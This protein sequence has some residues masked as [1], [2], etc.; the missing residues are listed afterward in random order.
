M[1]ACTAAAPCLTFDKAYHAAAAGATVQVAAGTYGAQTIKVDSTKNTASSD[2]VIQPATGA[3]VAIGTLLVQGAHVEIDDMTTGDVKLDGRSGAHFVTMRRNNIDGTFTST[4]AHDWLLEGGQV[5]SATPVASDPQIQSYG[6]ALN[7][8]GTVDG[9]WFHDFVD[10]GP[11]KLHHIECL[12]VGSGVNLRIT[13]NHFGPNCDTH[14]LF[15]R[16]WGDSVNGGPSPLTNVHVDGN[17]FEKCLPGCY[18]FYPLDDLYTLSPTSLVVSGNTFQPGAG[19]A[20]NW[21]HGSDSWFD[22]ILPSMSAFG[23]GYKASA[24][25][26]PASRFMHDNLFYG[27]ALGCGTNSILTPSA[28]GIWIADGVHLAPGSPAVDLFT[29]GPSGPDLDGTIRPVNGKWDAGADEK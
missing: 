29:V 24:A 14:D 6:S 15:I 10:V 25:S 13:N 9:V 18:A 3:N 4:G 20:S 21:S 7:T 17:V 5:H 27:P 16:S 19:I 28:A 1:K 23:C 26:I 2:V 22:N 11:G 12:Q 8:N